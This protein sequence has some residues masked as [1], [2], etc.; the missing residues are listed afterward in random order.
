MLDKGKFCSDLVYGIALKEFGSECKITFI[1]G[2]DGLEPCENNNYCCV[3]A[4][5]KQSEFRGIL[6]IDNIS[7]CFVVQINDKD[8][9]RSKFMLASDV[10]SNPE[11][12]PRKNQTLIQQIILGR[13]RGIMLIPDNESDALD[14]L[15]GLI[16]QGF[17]DLAS[18]YRDFIIKQ[19]EKS[20]N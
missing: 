3:N 7:Y 12:V 14:I 13:K 16:E 11:G 18:Q 17:S 19:I 6:N 5:I 4:T 8:E 2:F 10:L 9:H 1:R 20:K 15:E